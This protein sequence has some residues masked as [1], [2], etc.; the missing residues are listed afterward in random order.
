MFMA[1]TTQYLHKLL[2][3][4]CHSASQSVC[5]EMK[6]E[7]PGLISNLLV[8]CGSFLF[9]LLCGVLFP[10]FCDGQSQGKKKSGIML[11]SWQC[12][13]GKGT[14]KSAELPE[15]VQSLQQRLNFLG[16]PELTR[17]LIFA[18]LRETYADDEAMLQDALQV[19]MENFQL[20]LKD[21]IQVQYEGGAHRLRLACICTKGDWPWLITAGDLCRHFRRAAKRESAQNP[22]VGLCHF[23]MAGA[24]GIPSADSQPTA[25]WRRTMHSAASFY[26]WETETPITRMMPS[27]PR[28][29]AY[30]YR[31]DIFHNWHL[32]AG[33]S[34]GASALV[35]VSEL[36]HGSSIPA[37][38]ENLTTLWRAF[39]R[40]R[41]NCFV[42]KIV[43]C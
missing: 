8:W 10:M 1:L 27:S 40:S 14:T 5:T 25:K 39:C 42:L 16:P 2:K 35:L 26:A 6:A 31:P 15:D 23:C 24:P 7:A 18:A 3:M 32:G 19:C 41:T 17:H 12:T 29:P 9:G 11:I 38:F 20:A 13:L 28:F 37:R 30:V 34:F 21:G 4:I 22:N 36:C 33:Q 43:I